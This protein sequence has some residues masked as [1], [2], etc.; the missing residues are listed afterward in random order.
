MSKRLLGEAFSDPG[1][2]DPGIYPFVFLHTN[3]DEIEILAG[4]RGQ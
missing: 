4:G 1:L 3:Y 2:K